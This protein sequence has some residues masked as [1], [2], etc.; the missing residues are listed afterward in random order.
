ME[1]IHG[2][3]IHQCWELSCTHAELLSHRAEAKDDMQ[4][5]ANLSMHDDVIAASFVC[6]VLGI[7]CTYESKGFYTMLLANLKTLKHGRPA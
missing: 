6:L 3:A 2:C 5:I 7:R 4:I 1:P